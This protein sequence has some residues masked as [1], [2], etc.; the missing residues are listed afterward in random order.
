MTEKTQQDKIQ[1]I[2]EMLEQSIKALFESQKYMNYLKIM[3]KLHNYSLNNTLL[4]AMQRPDATMVAGYNAWHDN[5][6]RNVMKGEKGIRILAPSPYKLDKDIEKID[7]VTHE[8]VIDKNGKSIKERVQITIPAYKTTTVFDVSQTEGEPLPEI[9]TVLTENVDGFEQLFN[10]IKEISPVPIEIKE[11]SGK[12]NGYYHLQKKVIVIQKEMSQSQTLK[13]AIHELSHAILH[14]NDI[15]IE[16]DSKID[17]YTKEVQAE[18]VAYVVCCHYELDTSDYSFGY[19]AGWSTNREL[20]ELKNSMHIIHDTAS[21]IIDKIDEKIAIS[22][23]KEMIKEIEHEHIEDNSMKKV[24]E[25]HNV[26]KQHH[27]RH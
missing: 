21:E 22:K 27:R 3:S 6:H 12:A 14:D 19:I 11:I 25:K 8:P 26:V 16:K 5:F 17:K 2:L 1:E 18:S 15:G 4:I 10:A 7:P 23:Q 13:T 20:N 9:A 24:E